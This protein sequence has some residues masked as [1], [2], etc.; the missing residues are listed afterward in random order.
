MTPIRSSLSSALGAALLTQAVLALVAGAVL[1]NPLLERTDTGQTLANLAAQHV[2]ADV[3]VV[4]QFATAIAIVWL[5][6]LLRRVVRAVGG[7]AADT[8]AALYAVEAG[9]LVLATVFLHLAIRLAQAPAGDQPGLAPTAELG[10]LLLQGKDI[11]GAAA[12][13]AFG[14]GGPLFY[15]LLWR[16][17]VL[18]SWLPLW[19]L[20]SAPLVVVV[21]VANLYGAGIPF[22]VVFPYVPFEFMLGLYVLRRGLRPAAAW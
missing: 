17:R 3:A 6:M 15:G 10:R 20:L 4:M 21:I 8:A 14:I 7:V 2:R 16:A 9:L 5:G 18:P 12:I 11:A 19:G 13:V 1:T 22:P